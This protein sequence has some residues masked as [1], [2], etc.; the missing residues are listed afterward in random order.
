MTKKRGCASDK[1]TASKS[2]VKILFLIVTRINGN[3]KRTDMN[4]EV[5]FR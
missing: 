3:V 1:E 5:L 4:K 2:N